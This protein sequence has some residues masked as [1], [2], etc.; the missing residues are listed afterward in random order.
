M[1][2][3]NSFYNKIDCIY[4]INLEHRPQRNIYIKNLLTKY[5]SDKKIIR[6]NGIN[7]TLDSFNNYK[8]KNFN[9]IHVQYIDNNKLAK[10]GMLGCY[11]SHYFIL[12]KISNDIKKTSYKK[13]KYFLVFED[14]CVF[15]QSFI[16]FLKNDIND[17]LPYQWK[18]LRPNFG[19]EST[20]DAI[21]KYFYN[22]YKRYKID[23]FNGWNYYWGTHMNIYNG[24]YI[25][26][27]IN[28]LDNTYIADIDNLFNKTLDMSFTF[29]K[30]NMTISQKKNYSDTYTK[31]WKKKIEKDKLKN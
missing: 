18:L 23:K 5:F 11:L 30:K 13:Y 12:K 14:D 3:L 2:K 25:D 8:N 17:Y 6:I 28:L 9:R 15:D 7:N 22:S 16:N 27:I 31:E 10:P 4:Y 24:R 29:K 26:E 20:D 1:Y 21:N 19:K